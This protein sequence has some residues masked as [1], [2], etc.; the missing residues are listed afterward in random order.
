MKSENPDKEKEGMGGPLPRR[1]VKDRE[2][3]T[4]QNG[5]VP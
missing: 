1:G 4:N 2:R 5:R 3:M